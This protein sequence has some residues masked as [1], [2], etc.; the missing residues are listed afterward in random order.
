MGL[1]AIK[2]KIRLC[3]LQPEA[4]G[5]SA[6]S[7]IPLSSDQLSRRDHDLAQSCPSRAA[8]H[9]H[10]N[11]ALP[12]SRVAYAEIH[13]RRVPLI[14]AESKPII[15]HR[16]RLLLLPSMK[17]VSCR[18]ALDGSAQTQCQSKQ[19]DFLSIKELF[20]H[21]GAL[22]KHNSLS[23]RCNLSDAYLHSINR[24]PHTLVLFLFYQRAGKAFNAKRRFECDQQ[25]DRNALSK[26][27]GADYVPRC[28]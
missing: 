6:K 19:T 18:H 24:I 12:A 13:F 26:Q 4:T 28:V 22:R 10:A 23:G 20:T 21:V 14:Y 25:L 27:A 11:S 2:E 16:R 15:L 7:S 9:G 3:L 17:L 8:I 5:V 1:A